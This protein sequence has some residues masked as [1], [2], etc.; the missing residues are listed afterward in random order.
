MKSE[1]E[2]EDKSDT[3]N[4]NQF[5][6]DYVYQIMK[7]IQ[8]KKSDYMHKVN[9]FINYSSDENIVKGKKNENFWILDT[10][11]TNHVI[12]SINNFVT[13]RRINPFRINLPNDSPVVA[14]YDGTIVLFEFFFLYNVLYIP[15]F[16]FN[17]VSVQKLVRNHNCKLTITSEYC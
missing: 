13:F 7:L 8:E 5:T 12:L 1:E 17:L 16:E 6:L 2:Q 11:A 10:S 3:H 9:N 15:E 14:Y 4:V